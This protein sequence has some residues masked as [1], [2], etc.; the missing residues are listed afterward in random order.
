MSGKRGTK[1]PDRWIDMTK[2][3]SIAA[4]QADTGERALDAIDGALNMLSF[5]ATSA[6]RAAVR[7]HVEAYA[8]FKM[9]PHSE[10]ADSIMAA[11]SQAG[12][13]PT[14]LTAVLRDTRN[15]DVLEA[16]S[17]AQINA[18]VEMFDAMLGRGVSYYVSPRMV[19]IATDIANELEPMM[20]FPTDA[21]VS[22]GYLW[23]GMP[24][25]VGDAGEGAYDMEVPVRVLAW[26]EADVKHVP[27]GTALENSV[28]P[29]VGVESPGENVPGIAMLGLSAGAEV[30]EAV[31]RHEREHGLDSGKSWPAEMKWVPWETTAWGYGVEWRQATPQEDATDTPLVSGVVNQ[32]NAFLRKFLFAVWYLIRQE[33]AVVDPYRPDRHAARRMARTAPN[34]GDLQVI[35]LRR[36]YDPL[37]ELTDEERGERARVER[38][39]SHRWRVTE[40]WAWRACGPGRT[41][42]R[43][44]KIDSY[45]K[46]PKHLPLV[47][48][49]RVFSLER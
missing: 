19:R 28:G 22:A 4:A 13:S 17:E 5:F 9:V 37:C 12:L 25:K 49:D 26:Q 20:L 46:G 16:L 44:V 18:W 38:E 36:I 34:F 42:R 24:V 32:G 29:M 15:G 40:H 1:A 2:F 35:R 27:E 47:E 23:L 21:P 30:A 48:K 10:H 8:G 11:V 33:V 39:W 3:D 7:V 45:V 14:Q 6:G 43:L 31:S 41:E